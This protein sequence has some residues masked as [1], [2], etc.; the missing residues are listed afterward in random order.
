M[1]LQKGSY[2]L[3]MEYSGA[4]HTQ[5]FEGLYITIDPRYIP[6]SAVLDDRRISQFEDPELRKKMLKHTVLATHFE[7]CYARQVIP[8][9]DEPAFK[10]VF[11]VFY[12]YIYIYIVESICVR[13]RDEGNF[14]HGTG[15]GGEHSPGDAL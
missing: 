10:A 1:E 6:N 4:I 3:H 13:C 8:V 12:I 5:L 14:E 9:F 2:L 7:P 15:I 11:Q